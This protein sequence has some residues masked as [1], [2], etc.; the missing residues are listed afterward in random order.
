MEPGTA[1]YRRDRQHFPGSAVLA[2][3]GDDVDDAR[4][5]SDIR[6]RAGGVAAGHHDARGR[7]LARDPA[8]RLARALVRRRGD[9][10]A[11]DDDQVRVGRTHHLAA[12]R[13]QLTLDRLGLGLV[14]AAAEGQ[15]G[16]AQSH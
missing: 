5:R 1:S 8:D 9:R 13:N 2:F 12:G 16:D 14:H 6:G 11:V 7:V 15:E 10:A 3:I 4:Q